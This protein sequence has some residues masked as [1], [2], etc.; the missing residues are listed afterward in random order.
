MLHSAMLESNQK[1]YSKFCKYK[2][3]SNAVKA[4]ESEK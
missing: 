1:L 4:K 3:I 2:N